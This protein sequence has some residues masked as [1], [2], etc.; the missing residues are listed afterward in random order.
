LVPICLKKI[1]KQ[2]FPAPE[3]DPI[4]TTGAGDAFIGS[5]AY[6]LAKGLPLPDAIRFA[7]YA[8]ALSVTKVGTQTSFPSLADVERLIQQAATQ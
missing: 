4:D 8:A 2:L 6:A 7:N 3:V 5:L 1:I